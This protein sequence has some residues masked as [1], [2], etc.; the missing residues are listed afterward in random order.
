QIFMD[1]PAEYVPQAVV[2][3]F[4]QATQPV[5]GSVS[6]S[7]LPSTQTV[8][9][10]VSVSNLPSTQVVSSTQLPAPLDGSSFLKIHEQGTAN[11]SIQNP[12][13]AVTGTFWQTTQPVSGTVAVSA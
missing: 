5:N 6:V 2:G 10:S 13:L 12:S 4:W 7:N 11:V 9:G 3:T 1:V 8:S